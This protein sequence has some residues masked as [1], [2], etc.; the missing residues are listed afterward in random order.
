MSL[1]FS[2]FRNSYTLS[3]DVDSRVR[4]N[5]SVS[6]R[7]S[8]VQMTASLRSPVSSLYS[9][10]SRPTSLFGHVD[11][12]LLVFV[13]SV[14]I[15]VPGAMVFSARMRFIWLWRIHA[16]IRTA[17]GTFPLFRTFFSFR[18]AQCFCPL[19]GEI[20]YFFEGRLYCKHDFEILYS[21]VCTACCRFSNLPK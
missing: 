4:A 10:Y 2:S 14:L 1:W 13:V 20:Y 12:I 3:P 6:Y 8:M 5:S 7:Q 21:P 16:G 19:N 17:S 18:C 11:G 9:S 15:S